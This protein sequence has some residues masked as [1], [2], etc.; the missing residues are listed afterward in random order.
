MLFLKENAAT[1]HT[2]SGIPLVNQKFSIYPYYS[3]YVFEK[4][5]ALPAIANHKNSLFLE[6]NTAV[7]LFG[8]T[9]EEQNEEFYRN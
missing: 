6:G 3:D 5:R 9:E 4:G 2:G 7:F 1:S 8:I